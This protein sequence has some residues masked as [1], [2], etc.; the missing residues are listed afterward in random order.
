M[1]PVDLGKGSTSRSH[2][3]R[4]SSCSIVGRVGHHAVQ[5]V[6]GGAGLRVVVTSARRLV[7][8]AEVVRFGAERR[9]NSA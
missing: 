3:R 9:A 4:D 7:H 6:S 8:I 2:P 5:S 1:C